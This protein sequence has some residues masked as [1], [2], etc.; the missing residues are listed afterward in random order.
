MTPDSRRPSAARA[1]TTGCIILPASLF[2]GLMIASAGTAIYP[3]VAGVGAALLCS[4]EVI[5]ESH[6]QSY[7]P[8]EY[9]VTRQIYCRSGDGKGATQE[10]IT[11]RAIG[12]AFLIYSAIAFLLLHFLVA[13]WL[14]RRAARAML[15]GAEAVQRLRANVVVREAIDTSSE[16]P[17]ER[18]AQLRQLRDQGLITAAD[19]ESKKAEILKG[20]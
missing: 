14:R 3:R 15:A 17:A 19:Y 4:G 8:G 2:I 16:D 7:R 18:L 13:P 11:F 6:G 10:E 5:Y 20:L 1:G 12:L 9:T